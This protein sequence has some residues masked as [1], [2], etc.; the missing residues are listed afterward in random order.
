MVTDTQTEAL[1]MITYLHDGLLRRDSYYHELQPAQA[2]CAYLQS[3]F[4]DAQ[5]KLHHLAL[6]AK[7]DPFQ[8]RRSH[9][10]EL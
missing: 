1:F 3:I 7:T 4:P 10:L 9:F 2:H 8:S 6:A 5:V